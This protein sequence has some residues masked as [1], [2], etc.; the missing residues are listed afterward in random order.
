[1]DVMGI[2][3]TLLKVYDGPIGSAKR[4]CPDTKQVSRLTQFENYTSLEN[5]IR[6][7]VEALL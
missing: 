1:M 2:D 7:T 3:P 5:G 4:R 6:K